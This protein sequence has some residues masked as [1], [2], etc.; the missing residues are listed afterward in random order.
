VRC[1]ASGEVWVGTTADLAAQ[2]NNLDFQLRH[3]PHNATLRAAWRQHGAGGFTL[4]ALE[5]APEGLTPAGRADALKRAALH[6]RES[7]GA[8]AI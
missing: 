1:A 2:R 8:A 4:E 5:S 3:G 7:L 6:W